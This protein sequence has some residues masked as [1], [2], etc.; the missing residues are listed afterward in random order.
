MPIAEVAKTAFRIGVQPALFAMKRGARYRAAGVESA[1]HLPVCGIETMAGSQG[2]SPDCAYTIGLGCDHLTAYRSTDRTWRSRPWLGTAC[3]ICLDAYD[4]FGA[5]EASVRARTGDAFRRSCSKARRQGYVA[6]FF[7]PPYLAAQMA[8]I[9]ES[10]RFRSG[11]LV[12]Y[13]L[14]GS[15]VTGPDYGHV[16]GYRPAAPCPLHWTLHFG[17][18]NTYDA[19]GMSLPHANWS[20]V[21]F[22]KLR[23]IGNLVHALQHI[24]H[25]DHLK[26]GIM[27]L[28]HAE[29]ISWLMGDPHALSGGVKHYMYGALEHAGDGL[30][31]WKLRRGFEPMLVGIGC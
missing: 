12:P 24:G 16:D 31:A 25:G 27:D 29:L 21:A 17:V 3:V 22:V 7:H 11:G 15:R 19:A 1:D 8:A 28:V 26:A 13:G 30:A 5:Y 14:L 23:R 20:L 6:S 9:L 4:G 2:C 10:K 18:F